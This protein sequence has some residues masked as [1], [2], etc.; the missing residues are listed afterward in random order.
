MITQNI[1][2][3]ESDARLRKEYN[4]K[5]FAA[6]KNN[7]PRTP[8]CDPNSMIGGW[9]FEGYDNAIIQGEVLAS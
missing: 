1:A 3:P 2:T 8:P 6:K 4:S 7:Q 5:G 9:W